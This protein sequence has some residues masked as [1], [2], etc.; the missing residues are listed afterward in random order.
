MVDCPAEV[1]ATY[2]D[3]HGDGEKQAVAT[4]YVD[5][6]GN[7]IAKPRTSFDEND[8]LT[9]Y[10]LGDGALLERL[11]VARTSGIRDLSVV[12]VIGEGTTVPSIER[13]AAGTQCKMRAFEGIDSFAPGKGVVTIS[14]AKDEGIETVS[15]FELNV[16][17][18]YSGIFTLGAAVSDVVNPKYKL[19]TNGTDQV[20]ARGDAS[21][22]DTLF[23]VF[24]TPFVWGKRDV[25][26]PMTR[27]TWYRHINPSIGLVLDDV[28]KTSSRASASTF[29]AA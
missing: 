16:A 21:D 4:M 13:H 5:V 15:N 18:L 8:S 7:V 9:V 27:S 2:S 28:P 6:L 22:N 23:T 11:K 24:Y 26:K 10:V 14:R 25:E 29:R 3:T 12:R 1:S 20:I 17:P 19:V